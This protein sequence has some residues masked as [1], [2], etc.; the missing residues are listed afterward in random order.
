MIFD[1]IRKE[2]DEASSR[3]S[4]FSS[5][6]CPSRSTAADELF[7]QHY[8]GINLVLGHIK[9]RSERKNI[10][11]VT[12][13][14]QHQPYLPAAGIEVAFHS[15]NEDAVSEFA[16]RLITVFAANLDSK[17]QTNA[18]GIANDFRIPSM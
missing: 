2:W 13:D 18:V 7:K 12:T 17:C 5:F 1:S 4:N 9:A 3:E 10:L 8:R 11:V 14:I 16:I 6:P 15:F